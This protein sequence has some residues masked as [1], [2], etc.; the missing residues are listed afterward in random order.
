MDNNPID[1]WSDYL[2][3]ALQQQ[4]GMTPQEAKETVV[5]W[6]KSL[7]GDSAVQPQRLAREAFPS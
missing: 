2:A 7:D 1:F 6:F 4:Y 5:L 3:G